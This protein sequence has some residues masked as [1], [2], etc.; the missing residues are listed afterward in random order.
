MIVFDV[1]GIESTVVVLYLTVTRVAGNGF[2]DST[3]C[4]FAASFIFL[5]RLQ[6]VHIDVKPSSCISSVHWLEAGL[7]VPPDEVVSQG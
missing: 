3:G 1:G 4:R 6:K 5:R 7:V 2:D